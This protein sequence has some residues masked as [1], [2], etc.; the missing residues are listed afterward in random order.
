MKK[1]AVLV[2]FVLLLGVGAQQ[3]YAW[4]QG[5]VDS[6]AGPDGHLVAFTVTSGETADQIGQDLFAKGLIKNESVFLLYVRLTGA[7]AQFEAGQYQLRRDMTMAQIVQKLEHAVAAQVKI[8]IPEGLTINQVAKLVEA[9]GI[10]SA[11]DYQNAARA[12]Y[13]FDFLGSRPAGADLQGY[14]FPDTYD[15]DATATVS[16]LIRSQLTEFGKMFLPAWRTAI[17]KPTAARPAESI[18]DIVILASLVQGEA[19]TDPGKTCD[20]YYNRLADD[21]PLQVD[22][23][24][25]FAEGRSGAVTDQDHQFDSPYNTYLHTGL[26]PGPIGNPGATAL[27]ACVNPPKTPYLF[28]FTDR[29]NM[30]HFEVTLEQFNADIAQYGVKGS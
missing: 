30:T 25:L 27:Q 29:Q 11:Q 8:T 4:Y 28:Y 13:S 3:A 17:Q 10:G 18:E 5:Q 9:R 19:N 22:A 1:L 16:D 24:I 2:A 15:L 23:T 14:L 6:S 21:M 20:V 7:R 26:P 12:N